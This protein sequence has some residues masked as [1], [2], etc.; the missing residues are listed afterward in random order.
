VS[1]IG[2]GREVQVGEQ[3]LA[4]SQHRALGRLRLLH[5]DDHLGAREHL[6]GGGDHLRPR[7]HVGGIVHADALPRVVLDDH[8]V[9]VVDDLAH[10][11]G[12]EPDTVLEDLDFLRHA[13]LHARS[14]CVWGQRER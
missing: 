10:G 5:L 3:H 12:G 8:L 14:R 4:G 6:G 2:I 13:D 7:L 1:P 11:L 9:A